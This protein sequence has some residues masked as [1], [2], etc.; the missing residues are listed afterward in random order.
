METKNNFASFIA[1]KRKNANLTQK[2]LSCLIHVSESAVS[3]WER[4]VSYPDISLISPICKALNITEHEFITA[5][6]DIKAKED[7]RRLDKIDNREK[8]THIVLI[9]MYIV[10]VF[11]C[12]LCNIIIDKKLSWSIIV[13]VSI[14]MFFCTFNLHYFLKK[15]KVLISLSAISILVY[16]LLLAIK[17]TENVEWSFIQGATIATIW[18]FPVWMIYL[19]NSKLKDNMIKNSTI[20]IVIGLFTI[21]INP[22]IEVIMTNNPFYLNINPFDFNTNPKGNALVSFILIIIA[23]ALIIIKIMKGI[24][25]NNP[26]DK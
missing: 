12:I 7:K 9:G 19:I 22:L 13:L 8:R 1:D 4:G 16:I 10:A 3:K 21:L 25:S 5:S 17:V 18:L 26:N 11:I 23:I 14:C 15:K 6:D 2:E 20:L 24:K